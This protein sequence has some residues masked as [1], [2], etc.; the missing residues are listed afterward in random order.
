DYE[1][2][3]AASLT[4]MGAQG[5][6]PFNVRCCC[7]LLRYRQPEWVNRDYR[8][9]IALGD[10]DPP[11]GLYEALRAVRRALADNPDDAGLHF[12]LGQM[13]LHLNNYTRERSMA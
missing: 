9:F 7:L 3:L 11:A 2:M 1:V 6:Y 4:A 13:A 10:N 8:A 12:L 5:D